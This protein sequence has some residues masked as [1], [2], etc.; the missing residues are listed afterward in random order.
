MLILPIM[1]MFNKKAP[2][3]R[4]MVICDSQQGLFTQD[5]IKGIMYL[6]QQANGLFMFNSCMSLHPFSIILVSH[7]QLH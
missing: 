3:I 6:I 7:L 5:R 4:N 1:C 2:R